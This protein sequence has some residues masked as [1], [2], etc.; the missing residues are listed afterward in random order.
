[1][2]VQHLE[3]LIV[4]AVSEILQSEAA[5]IDPKLFTL[6]IRHVNLNDLKAP[7]VELSEADESG[8]QDDQ[9]SERIDEGQAVS[10][11]DESAFN[12][13]LS[14]LRSKLNSQQ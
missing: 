9:P 13:G 14:L 2:T 4:S 7:S 11:E 6:I 3:K 10:S 5:R 1:M 12:S 8:E